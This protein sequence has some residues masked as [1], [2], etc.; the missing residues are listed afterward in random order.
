V[1]DIPT[2]S[3]LADVYFAGKRVKTK[4]D[5]TIYDNPNDV[6]FG[7]DQSGKGLRADGERVLVDAQV[8]NL[9][10]VFNT[11]Y[12]PGWHAWLTTE[13]DN[14]FVKDLQI[15]PVTDGE[16]TGRIEVH[17]PQGRYWL[18]LRFEDSPPRVVGW[19]ISG[20]SI[21]ITLGILI[22]EFRSKKMKDKG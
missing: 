15:T 11:F 17:V 4:I 13:S 6:W 8:D 16:P 12:Y 7:V 22:W 1:K 19:W 9:P 21:L 2:W 18:N 20:L 3:P 5:M 14:Q 10:V